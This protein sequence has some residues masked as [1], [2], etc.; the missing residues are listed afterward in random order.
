MVRRNIINRLDD[1]YLVYNILWYVFSFGIMSCEIEDFVEA[2][3]CGPCVIT[4]DRVYYGLSTIISCTINMYVIC[5]YSKYVYTTLDVN[6]RT[7]LSCVFIFIY[8]RPVHFR[9][10]VVSL[11]EGTKSEAI[12]TD[13]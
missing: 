4:S 6:T 1:I 10:K 9:L 2:H 11:A 12:L 3:I 13:Q 5:I 7:G 8:K